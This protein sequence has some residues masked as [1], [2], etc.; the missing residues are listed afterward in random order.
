MSRLGLLAV[1]RIVAGLAT[2][3]A[4]AKSWGAGVDRGGGTGGAV[5]ARGDVVREGKEGLTANV[6]VE[7]E[8]PAGDE[9]GTRENQ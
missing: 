1:L 8:G 3:E 2:V 9:R 5:V 4:G 6:D 7:K